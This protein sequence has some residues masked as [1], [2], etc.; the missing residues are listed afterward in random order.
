VL[1]LRNLTKEQ[2]LSLVPAPEAEDLIAEGLGWKKIADYV[3]ST[4]RPFEEQ[5]DFYYTG[6][7]HLAPQVGF[8]PLTEYKVRKITHFRPTANIR[9]A[10]TILEH[11]PFSKWLSSEALNTVD[12]GIYSLVCGKSGSHREYRLD[13]QSTKGWVHGINAPTPA[14]AICKAFL[15]FLMKQETT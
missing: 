1:T 11:S 5:Q 8:P 15:C 14:L 9:D 13:Y 6:P 3:W 7:L 2:I 10:W 4:E 12:S